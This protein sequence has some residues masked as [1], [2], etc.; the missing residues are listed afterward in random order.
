MRSRRVACET[1]DTQETSMTDT[2]VDDEELVRL[3]IGGRKVRRQRLS[4]LALARLLGLQKG[5]QEDDESEEELGEEG[6]D[7]ERRLAR[8]VIGKG[9]VRRAR[10]R[11]ALLAHL[12]R[13]RHG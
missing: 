7:L 4:Q 12:L 3:A 10:L 5:E 1:D 13:E 8:L 2:T 6:G 9:V 11:R